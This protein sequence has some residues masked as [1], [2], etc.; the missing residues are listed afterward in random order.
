MNIFKFEIRNQL[1]SFFIWTASI[2][3]TLLI[4]MTAIYPVFNESTVDILKVIDGFP[5][6]F[7]AAFG[8]D[9]TIM[10]GFDGFYGFAFGYISLV[11]AIMA[12]NIAVTSF[13]REKRSKCADFLLV[14]PLSRNRIFFEKMLAGL[15]LLATTNVLYIAVAIGIG[16]AGGTQ[17]F[18][19]ALSLFLTQLVFYALG[20]FFATFAKKIRS[21]SGIAT[22][23]GFAA[24]ILSALVNILEEEALRFIAPLRY[25]DP[26]DIFVLGGYEWQ[27]VITAAVVIIVCIVASFVRFTK[28]DTNAV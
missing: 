15:C 9:L 7:A 16:T 14:K 22:A 8:F 1:Q 26:T 23:F 21:V 17:M 28:S 19:P 3:G 27:Y 4:F 20:I 6:G 10:F 25:F 13:A 2:L 12:V 5:P 24:F 11:G 18:L